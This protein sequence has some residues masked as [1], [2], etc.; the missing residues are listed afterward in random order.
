MK[1]H[2]FTCIALLPI[3]SFMTLADGC[4][5]SAE[6]G[7]VIIEARPETQGDVVRGALEAL[8]DAATK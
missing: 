2:V 1:S 3:L 4:D 8:W 5:G 7:R 6:T